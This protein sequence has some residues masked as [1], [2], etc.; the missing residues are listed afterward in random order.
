MSVICDRS[1]VFSGYSDFLHC[2]D[3]NE[4]LL[5]V[6]LNI[7]TPLSLASQACYH[8]ITASTAPFLGYNVPIVV[9]LEYSFGISFCLYFKSKF[10]LIMYFELWK[11]TIPI[12]NINYSS[13]LSDDVMIFFLN[14][15]FRRWKSAVALEKTTRS[16]KWWILFL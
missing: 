9:L 1:V 15:N 8:T 10:K 14:F 12:K 5:K 7:I 2:H 16:V 3:I 4:I 13:I 11:S 6:A